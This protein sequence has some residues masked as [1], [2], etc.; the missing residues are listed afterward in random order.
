MLV[1]LNTTTSNLGG[2]SVAVIVTVSVVPTWR[3]VALRDV[4]LAMQFWATAVG[5]KKRRRSNIGAGRDG[6][7]PGEKKL[8]ESEA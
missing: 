2:S 7:K 1:V 8:M 6:L 5:W 4:I 3:V